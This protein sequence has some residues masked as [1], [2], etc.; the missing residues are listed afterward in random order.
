MLPRRIGKA[1]A[2]RIGDHPRVLAQTSQAHAS[3]AV[4]RFH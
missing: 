3:G 4:A 2:G 1:K